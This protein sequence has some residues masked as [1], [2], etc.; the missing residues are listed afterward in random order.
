MAPRL[1]ALVLVLASV[2]ASVAQ[3]EISFE[4]VTVGDPGNPNDPLTGVY[5]GGDT[6]PT[7]GAV[8]YVYSISKYETTIGQ[9]TA[10]LNAVAKSDPQRAL[11][12]YSSQLGQLDTIRGIARFVR[13]G[14]DVFSEK[15]GTSVSRG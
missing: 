5:T 11:E 2:L 10:F 12:L 1:L 13:D 7:R 14:K 8:P 3:S 15:T 9:Y 6:P 4:W